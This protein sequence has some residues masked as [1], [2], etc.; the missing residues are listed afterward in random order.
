MGLE[1]KVAVVTGGGRGIG[2]GIARSL[3][4]AGAT[5]VVV[6]RTAPGLEETVELLSPHGAITRAICDVSDPDSVR[7]LFGDVASRH[8]GVDI[9]VCSH[10]VLHGGHSV[11]DHPV[12]LWDETIAVNLKGTFL[13]GQAAARVMVERECRG[14]IINISSIVAVQSAP[15]E[16]AYDASK[17]GVEALTRAMTLDLAQYGITVNSVSPGW[18][19]T[20]MV[21]PF[22][23]P[24]VERICNPLRH[25]G[26]PADVGN[27]VV[28]L[29][30]PASSQI[31]GITIYVDGGQRAALSGNPLNLL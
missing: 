14:R 24:E 10:G 9:L 3:V 13:C 26:E 23:T 31:T 20:P 27:A 22:M 16:V 15:Q 25:F 29:A 30:D 17:G 28:W 12:D 5:V 11:L 4:E 1:G 21:E 8:G 19:R 18:I 2:R 6:G 7:G